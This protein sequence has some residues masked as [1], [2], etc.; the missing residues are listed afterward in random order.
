MSSFKDP[1][2]SDNDSELPIRSLYRQNREAETDDS[3]SDTE[4]YQSESRR[5]RAEPPERIPKYEDDDD[6]SDI[7]GEIM[8][9]RSKRKT[10]DFFEYVDEDEYELV[11]DD[12]EEEP[13]KKHFGKFRSKTGQP[14]RTSC[15]LMMRMQPTL[16]L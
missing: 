2:M 8:P 6:T 4:I 10:E 9:E 3:T 12:E 11:E 16:T 7:Y 14:K 15:I 1:K 5:R 13:A